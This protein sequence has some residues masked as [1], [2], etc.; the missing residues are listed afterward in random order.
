M[1]PLWAAFSFLTKIPTPGQKTLTE[2][3]LV[4]GTSFFPLVGLAI[5][6]LL[7]AVHFLATPLFPGSNPLAVLLLVFWVALS[8]A[9]HLDGL[10]DSFDG[11]GGGSNREE[12]LHIMKDSGTGTF[13]LVAVVLLLLFKYSLLQA[14]LL[15]GS[16]DT[17]LLLAPVLGRWSMTVLMVITPYAGKK[18]SLGRPFI[19]KIGRKHLLA[20]TFL[21][22]PLGLIAPVTFFLLL[23]P[24]T[25]LLIYLLRNLYLQ[26]I[27]GI[28]GDTTGATCELVELLALLVFAL[29]LPWS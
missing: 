9:L 16:A 13:G 28:T 12:R 10:S 17:A 7:Y 26:K 19:E 11:L 18:E 2:E 6:A 24:L 14:L 8:G 29:H 25:L 15:Q 5:G 20:A 1:H 22:L 4:K 27:G 3:S 23:L 21:T